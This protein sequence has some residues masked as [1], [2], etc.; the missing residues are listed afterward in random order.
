MAVI[1]TDILIE[2]VRRDEVL[3]WLAKPDNHDRFLAGTFDEVKRTSERTWDL[4][5]QVA[6]KARSLTYEI[7]GV[8][9]SHGGRRLLCHTT[10]KRT[11]GKLH[12]SL[13]TMKPSSNTLVT[14]HSDYDPGG[15]IGLLIDS[16]GLRAGLEERWKK[17]L[18]NLQRELYVDHG[19]GRG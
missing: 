5:L 9:D 17:V 19:G 10:G 7:D 18:F 12:Y 8:D 11:A 3:D 15:P 4:T 16:A 1:T 6:P 2:G 13:R 14:L